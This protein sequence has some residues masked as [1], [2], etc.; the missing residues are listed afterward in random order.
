M[1]NYFEEQEWQE[2]KK[3]VDE[4]IKSKKPEHIRKKTHNPIFG[5]GVTNV[6]IDWE[7]VKLFNTR[8]Y[9]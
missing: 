8:G 1:A 3:A 4:K 2:T 7:L 5:E 9:K 6:K